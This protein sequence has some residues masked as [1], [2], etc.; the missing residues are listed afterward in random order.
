MGLFRS[1]EPRPAGVNRMR[2]T[3]SLLC[4]CTL[5]LAIALGVAADSSGFDRNSHSP[6]ILNVTIVKSRDIPPY[7]SALR[8]FFRKLGPERKRIR[9]KVFSLQEKG[10]TRREV[11]LKVRESAPDI[12]L[13]LGTAATRAILEEKPQVPII[14]SLVLLSSTQ[15]T[16]LAARE[17]GIDITGAGMDVPVRLQFEKAREMLP[18]IKRIGVFYN[19]GETGQVVREAKEVAASMGLDLVAI[20]IRS[21]EELRIRLEE[22]WPDVDLLWSVA[23]GTIFTLRTGKVI[24]LNTLRRRIPFVGLSPSFVKAGALISFSCNYEAVGAQ[25]ADQAIRIFRGEKASSIPMSS[26]R[27][28]SYYLNMKTAKK[29]GVDVPADFLDKAETLF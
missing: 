26:P 4:L 8:G 23:D 29:I 27:E 21:E 12:I 14:F 1:G 3:S 18:G 24:L 19:P 13:T 5:A 22:P 7:E 17:K 9:S 2:F 25:A 11:L 28:I 16:F 6:R 15:E 20:P 10:S